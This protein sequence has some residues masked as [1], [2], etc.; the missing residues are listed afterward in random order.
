MTSSDR[1]GLLCEHEGVC[2]IPGYR[3][4]GVF[5]RCIRDERVIWPLRWGRCALAGFKGYIGVLGMPSGSY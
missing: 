4:I 5:R 1:V 3:D 2:R